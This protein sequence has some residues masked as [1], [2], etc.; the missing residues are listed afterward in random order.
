MRKGPKAKDTL[1]IAINL[2]PVVREHY[3]IGV[4]FKTKW[5]E[6]FNTDDIVYYGSGINNKGDITPLE[7]GHNNQKYAIDVNLPPLAVV[8]FK[9]K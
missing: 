9:S 3:R 2:T 6:I 5:T 1:V 8:V 4:P 7:E